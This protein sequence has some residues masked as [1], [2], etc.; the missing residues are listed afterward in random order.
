MGLIARS[1]EAAGIATVSISLARD[2]TQAVGVPRAVFLKWPLGHPLGEPE[3]PP[4]Q[5]T[6]MFVALQTLLTA[7]APGTIVE[8]GYRWRRQH[9]TEP[10]WAQLVAIRVSPPDA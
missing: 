4:Q 1:L 2:L 8:P 7:E 9:Y 6:V 10:D 5:R 3:Q